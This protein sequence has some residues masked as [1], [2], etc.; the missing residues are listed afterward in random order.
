MAGV[1]V[2]VALCGFEGAKNAKG[3][4]REPVCLVLQ[5]TAAP[6]R[7]AAL[8]PAALVR[9]KRRH[10]QRAPAL[11]DQTRKQQCFAARLKSTSVL[12]RVKS[13]RTHS[14]AGSVRFAVEGVIP[15]KFADEFND[16]ALLTTGIEKPATAISMRFSRAFRLKRRLNAAASL[17]K[18]N[19]TASERQAQGIAAGA[20]A[21]PGSR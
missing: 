14:C 10:F 2:L 16:S 18:G 13:F 8:M 4:E 21:N 1:G 12:R 19:A 15:F 3:L 7:H 5:N 6:A 9:T 17:W 20:Q 11:K